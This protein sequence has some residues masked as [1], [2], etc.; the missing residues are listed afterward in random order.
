LVWARERAN[1]P[2]NIFYSKLIIAILRTLQLIISTKIT[3]IISGE[4]YSSPDMDYCSTPL[5]HFFGSNFPFRHFILSAKSARIDR[6]DNF[7]RN[8]IV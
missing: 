1:F 3:A 2:S 4:K 7:L 8:T 6:K 5:F